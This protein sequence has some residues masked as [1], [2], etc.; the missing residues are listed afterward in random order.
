MEEMGVRMCLKLGRCWQGQCGKIV[1]HILCVCCW[2]NDTVI[3]SGE[4]LHEYS[5]ESLKMILWPE[6][7]VVFSPFFFL[8][9]I[10]GSAAKSSKQ[11]KSQKSAPLAKVTLSEPTVTLGWWRMHFCHPQR[12][13]TWDG[14]SVRLSMFLF[15]CLVGWVVEVWGGAALASIGCHLWPCKREVMKN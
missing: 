12:R 8:I 3:S 6:I 10:A 5:T 11:L 7:C 15:V 9:V 13:F 2:C 4:T 1:S 14:Y